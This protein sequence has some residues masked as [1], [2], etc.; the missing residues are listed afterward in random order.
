MSVLN[1]VRDGKTVTVTHDDGDGVVNHVTEEAAIEHA[2]S[3][4]P[5]EKPEQIE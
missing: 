1:V 4:I 5:A 3:F 2:A